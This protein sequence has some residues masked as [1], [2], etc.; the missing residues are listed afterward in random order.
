[1]LQKVFIVLLLILAIAGSSAAEVLF[2]EDF[3]NSTAA[4]AR[5]DATESLGW[6]SSPG[7]IRAGGRTRA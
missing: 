3:A 5:F 2:E 1:M 7:V 4:A 6:V